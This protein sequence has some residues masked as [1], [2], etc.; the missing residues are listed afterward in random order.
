[1][2]LKKYINLHEPVF[3]GNEKKYL[4][5]CVDST[6]VSSIGNYINKFETNLSKY[7]KSKYVTNT[8]NGTAALHL[9]LKISNIKK[10]QEV[11][12]PSITFI[13]PINAVIYNNSN[14][15]FM[16]CDE[17]F[18]IDIKK[19]LKF[20]EEETIFKN[21]KTIN[22]SSGAIIAAII[23]VHV[24][25]NAV[26]LDELIKVCKKKNI[27][28][29]E[30]ASESLGTIYIKGKYKGRHVGTIADV[31]CL[32]FNGNKIITAGAGGA[33]L[34]NNKNFFEKAKYYSNQSKDDQLFFIHNEVGYNYR[35]SNLNA[36]VGLAQLENIDSII[37]KKKI[38]RK[39]Y[40]NLFDG[41]KKFSLLKNPNYS[42]NN[43]WL[44][45]MIINDCNIDFFNKLLKK[46]ISKGINI[47]PIWYP[48]HLQKTFKKFQ[49]YNIINAHKVVR[50]S[51][52][53][54]SS[55][56]ITIREIN[57]I[58]NVLDLWKK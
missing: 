18:N 46:F 51:I 24:F 20:I 36:A 25:G 8:I 31:G 45:I 39:L 10:N 38:V 58:K 30:D 13:A 1:M 7:T 49:R 22:K 26:F 5:E 44:N 43:N 33:V 6:F 23:I 52:C 15:I 3:Y 11:I 50:N 2:K 19:I 29:I 32:S 27:I 40:V 42:I 12:V 4:N 57:K 56:F 54:P 17:Y 37:K 16:D 48:N 55:S 47:R 14:P 35:M 9:A 21:Y 34:T 53:L 28:I 41:Y